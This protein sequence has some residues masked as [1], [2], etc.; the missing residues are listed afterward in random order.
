M[1]PPVVGSTWRFQVSFSTLLE[2]IANIP[3]TNPASD[4]LTGRSRKRR[5]APIVDIRNLNP[6]V[7]SER[8]SEPS[9]HAETQPDN[10]VSQ[11]AVCRG[12]ETHPAPTRKQ[13]PFDPSPGRVP[14]HAEIASA[15]AMLEASWIA[16]TSSIVV[17][18]LVC[19]HREH[20]G[21]RA[22]LQ[23][24]PQSLSDPYIESASAKAQAAR[25]RALRRSA[26]ARSS[27]WWQ[28]QPSRGRLSWAPV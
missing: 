13:R 15:S 27:A 2:S 11:G 17:Q 22:C 16:M 3:A 19:L 7:I 6:A 12:R 4:T 14:M 20:V 1:L 18:V 9:V 26:H 5:G 24:N 28:T 8:S 21:L 10:A 25:H 23:R